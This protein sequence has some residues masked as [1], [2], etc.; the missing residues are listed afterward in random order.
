MAKLTLGQK[1]DRVMRLLIGLRNRRIAVVLVRHGFTNDDLKEGWSLLQQVTRTQ[2]D[3]APEVQPEDPVAIRNLD[4]WENKWFPIASAT[5]KRRLPQ[6][7]AWLF[8]NLSQTEGPAVMVSVGTFVDRWQKLDKPVKDGGLGADGKA[9]T[10]IL[11][12][13]GLTEKVIGEAKALLE[14]LGRIDAPLPDLAQL[15]EEAA[16]FSKAETALWD[17]YLEWSEIVRTT[18]T[19][20]GLLKQLGFLRNTGAG[21]TEEEEDDTAGEEV[22]T[23]AEGKQEDAD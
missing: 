11:T 21:D 8:R 13:R 7:H 2:L 9:A 4:D 16:A 18:I 6:V 3:A 15:E 5:L 12:R 14:K 1:V 23:V 10:K 22:E 20:R 17:W 19:H